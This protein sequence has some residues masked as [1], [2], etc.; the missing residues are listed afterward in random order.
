MRHV[1]A[2]VMAIALL[3]AAASS[4][5]VLLVH[6]VGSALDP[7]T[8]TLDISIHTPAFTFT[9]INL[10]HLAPITPEN[11]DELQL[12]GILGYGT[13]SD[14]AWSPDGETLALASSTGVVLLYNADA[15]DAPPRRLFRH[16]NA[17]TSLVFSPDGTILASTSQDSTVLWQLATGEPL[18]LPEVRGVES[19][20]F[21]PDGM[22][23]ARGV[24]ASSG[25]GMHKAAQKSPPCAATPGISMGY[26]LAP[27]AAFWP[28]PAAIRPSVCG[29]SPPQHRWLCWTAAIPRPPASPCGT[30]APISRR[31]GT[32]GRCGCWIGIM[33]PDSSA[34]RCTGTAGTSRR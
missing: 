7:P 33:S 19:L 1:T 28:L 34:W 8:D 25:C 15:L 24:V 27:A 32:T 18:P 26:P 2:L 16:S 14:L 20:A 3:L 6:M 17:V 23:L 22:L 9:P 30:I 29:M 11:A 13:F 5:I 10:E 12:L 4:L 21:S 31:E